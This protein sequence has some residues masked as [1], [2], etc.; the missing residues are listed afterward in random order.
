MRRAGAKGCSP[1]HPHVVEYCTGPWQLLG[2]AG[3]R[4]A[5]PS[6]RPPSQRRQTRDTD[7]ARRGP[8]QRRLFRARRPPARWAGPQS[9]RREACGASARHT[10]WCGRGPR[11]GRLLRSRRA[12]IG[13]PPHPL[14]WAGPEAAS[15]R[16][17]RWH[18]GVV[19][20]LAAYSWRRPATAAGPTL[21]NRRGTSSA[22]LV[23][24][25]RGLGTAAVA[26]CAPPMLCVATRRP[27][28]FR[29]EGTR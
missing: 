3:P 11:R 18:G 27:V 9:A 25:R 21:L 22:T 14:R 13:R 19:Y 8:T 5:T 23:A 28:R 15:L 2:W 16:R 7:G 29:A 20:V 17:V 4:A 10:R 26:G 1:S 24:A 12:G 6:S